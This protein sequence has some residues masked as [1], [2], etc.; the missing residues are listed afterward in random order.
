[1]SETRPPYLNTTSHLWLDLRFDDGKHTG[2]RVLRGT[3]VI[4]VQRDGRKKIVDIAECM[5][6]EATPKACYDK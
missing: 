6:I 2:V 1:M 3:T 5:P 4:E